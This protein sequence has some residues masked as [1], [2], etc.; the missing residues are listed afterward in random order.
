MS[1]QLAS[2]AVFASLSGCTLTALPPAV[3]GNEAAVPAA[4]AVAD[5]GDGSRALPD[6]KSPCVFVTQSPSLTASNPLPPVGQIKSITSTSPVPAKAGA[7]ATTI[8]S[9]TLSNSVD[10]STLTFTKET[11]LTPAGAPFVVGQLV[12]YQAKGTAA[13]QLK[14]LAGNGLLVGTIESVSGRRMVKTGYPAVIP[15]KGFAPAT[16]AS[17]TLKEGAMGKIYAFTDATIDQGVE[18]VKGTAVRFSVVPAVPGAASSA[19]GAEAIEPLVRLPGPVVLCMPAPAETAL[20]VPAKSEKPSAAP[21]GVPSPNGTLMGVT[22]IG[23]N[24]T[25]HIYSGQIVDTKLARAVGFQSMAIDSQY[26]LAPGM[27][28]YYEVGTA[29]TVTFLAF[30]V[31]GSQVVATPASPTPSPSATS[32]SK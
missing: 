7:P 19:P 24:V 16:L 11:V 30:F 14:P 28:V 4:P 2:F 31:M 22:I 32:K 13:I 15:A 29:G 8:V 20:P 3:P 6:G 27:Q 12:T 9:G 23:A 21:S 1:R 17:G 5:V 10:G 26:Y 25:Q 18:L